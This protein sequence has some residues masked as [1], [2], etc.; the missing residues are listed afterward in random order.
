[1]TRSDLEVAFAAYLTE[2]YKTAGPKRGFVSCEHDRKL[3]PP[4]RPFNGHLIPFL[5]L[6]DEGLLALSGDINRSWAMMFRLAAWDHVIEEIHDEGL[7]IGIGYE[8]VEPL[9][10]W[11][12]MTS[13]NIKQRFVFMATKT[14]MVSKCLRN[15]VTNQ[16]MT[17]DHQIQFSTLQAW[18]DPSNQSHVI[19]LQRVKELDSQAHWAATQNFRRRSVHQ[20]PPHLLV[21]LRMDMQVSKTDHGFEYRFG[22]RMPIVLAESLAALKNEHQKQ[23]SAFVAFLRLAKSEWQCLETA[24]PL[25]ESCSIGKRS[26][27]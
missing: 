6:V 7:R 21:G 5:D 11:S 18:H 23:R 10:E 14:L 26:S 12:L 2:L 24:F 19:F 20:L 4:N 27:S 15:L 8:M 17:E 3:F 25:T 1:M 13:Y 22:A 9:M 16:P